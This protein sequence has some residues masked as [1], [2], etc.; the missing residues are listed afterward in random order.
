MQQEVIVRRVD[1]DVRVE[2][3]VG[4]VLQGHGAGFRGGVQSRRD[5]EGG[6]QTRGEV[7]DAWEEGEDSFGRAGEGPDA[8]A[9]FRG[10]A[11]EEDEGAW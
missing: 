11:G 10:E 8:E 5:G 2:G 6:V 7:G 9:D 3:E 4:V 1:V